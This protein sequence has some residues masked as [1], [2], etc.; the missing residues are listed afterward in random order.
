M[1]DGTQI[2]KKQFLNLLSCYGRSIVAGHQFFEDLAPNTVRNYRVGCSNF[3]QAVMDNWGTEPDGP[4]NP[5]DAQALVDDLIDTKGPG[6]AR[7]TVAS[8]GSILSFM[9][10]YTDICSNTYNPFDYVRV[11][12]SENIAPWTKEQIAEHQKCNSSY[13]RSL[14]SLL[15]ETGQRLSDVVDL[16]WSD[17][18]NLKQ[19]E[20]VPRLKGPPFT[21]KSVRIVQKKTRTI[22]EIPI[23]A[24]SLLI[25]NFVS[26]VGNSILNVGGDEGTARSRYKQHCND[27]GIT[28]L[29]LH[30]LRKS[31][32]IRMIE[33]GA[34]EYEIMAITGHK[35]TSSLRAYTKGYD[36]A[37]AGRE[38][39]RKVE[40]HGN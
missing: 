25:A 8:M 27:L 22:V 17:F 7:A 28:P 19:N 15:Y 2:T 13:V 6:S 1:N 16:K 38:A 23:L 14:V 12:T 18:L 31:A 29:Q 33:A 24:G 5:R 37:R 32:V 4:F 20:D 21:K 30:G 10:L 34:T 39:Y 9:I 3:L 35:S 11:P 40:A 36:V 26:G